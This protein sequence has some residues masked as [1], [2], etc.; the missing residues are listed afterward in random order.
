VN[1]IWAK[2]FALAILLSRFGDE[3]YHIQ[4]NSVALGSPTWDIL[5]GSS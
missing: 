1:K 5:V 3:L 2:L 4:K